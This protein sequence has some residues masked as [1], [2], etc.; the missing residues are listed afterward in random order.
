MKKTRCL[1]LIT[2]LFVMLL[3]SCAQ[4]S[5]MDNEVL[6]MR[7]LVG[8][9]IGITPKPSETLRPSVAPTPH[10]TPAP[11][12]TPTL[13]PGGMLQS[14]RVFTAQNAAKPTE[15]Q[16]ALPATTP[17]EALLATETPKPTDTPR[18]TET[19][20][21]VSSTR[22]KISPSTQMSFRELTADNKDKRSP[23]AS[24]GKYR[25]VVDLTNQI[26]TVYDR[27]GDIVRQMLC[28]TGK[29]E[30]PSPRGKYR[31]GKGRVRFGF[32]KSYD[33]YAQYWTQ[34][35]RNIY[36]HS[37]LYNERNDKSLIRSSYRN[38]GKA[39]SHGCIRLSVPDARWIYYHI[40][41]GTSIEL[42]KRPKNSA[43]REELKLPSIPKKSKKK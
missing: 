16:S 21:P 27:D 26:M 8:T 11:R 43:L 41:P 10:I 30:T 3:T 31:I 5:P 34:V 4:Q 12:I 36:I 25:I 22:A 14:S 23:R 6:R 15:A 39:V 24:K 17:N 38:L 9:G 13:S 2:L 42:K 32:F 19:P 35:T 37:V 20:K 7:N 1:S 28:S 29:S 33:C 40:A 18:P